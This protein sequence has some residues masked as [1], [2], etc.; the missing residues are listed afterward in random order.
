MSVYSAPKC[1]HWNPYTGPKSPTSL[2]LEP[3]VLLSQWGA[4]HQCAEPI[5]H[6]INTIVRLYI[7]KQAANVMCRPSGVSKQGAVHKNHTAWVHVPTPGLEQLQGA[8]SHL[9]CRPMLSRYS[10]EPL[11][12][13][14][15]TPF[16]FSTRASVLPLMNHSSSSATPAHQTPTFYAQCHPTS[17]AM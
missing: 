14:I 15:P 4:M 5:R 8:G 7:F 11:P 17:T 6:C 9:C 2:Q 12:S 10:R 13:Q 3:W 1:R 16:C